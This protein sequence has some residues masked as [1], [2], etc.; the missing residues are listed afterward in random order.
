M[1]MIETAY[2]MRNI[3]GTLVG[4]EELELR[5]GWPYKDWIAT[6]AQTPRIDGRAVAKVVVDAYARR[7]GDSYLTTLSGLDLAHIGESAAA[8]S[9]FADA[10]IARIASQALTIQQARLNCKNYGEAA[11]MHNPVD[12]A[13]FLEQFGATTSDAALKDSAGHA[14]EVLR[15]LVITNYASKRVQ[16]GYGSNGVSIYFPASKAFFDADVPDNE[17]YQPENSVYPVEFVQ[18]EK[19]AKLLH[20]YFKYQ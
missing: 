8:L 3:A 15:S 14:R 6:L 18:K 1:S 10:V 9:S 5:A 19:W 4:S 11:E 16:G 2:A 17:G 12:L 7:Y 13:R 20:A